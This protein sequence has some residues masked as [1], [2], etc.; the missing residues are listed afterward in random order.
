M[1]QNVNYEGELGIIKISDEVVGIIAGLAASEV[2][3]I[4]SLS[5]GKVEE[6]TQK[7]GGKKNILKGV[8]VNVNGENAVIDLFVI[9][10]FGVKITEVA[11]KVQTNVK[12]TV[13]TLTGLLVDKV[14]VYIQNIQI[15]K[16]EGN[17]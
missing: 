15:V 12:N 8:K 11:E 1:E 9:V 6:W 10:E 3:G 5:L 16:S 13:E 17:I 4:T 7:L 14:N 2:K